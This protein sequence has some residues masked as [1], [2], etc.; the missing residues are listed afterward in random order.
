MR[1]LSH[2][3]VISDNLWEPLEIFKPPAQR[4]EKTEVC[5]ASKQAPGG[6]GQ[7]RVKCKFHAADPVLRSSSQ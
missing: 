5:E 6:L 7:N 3:C 2:R 1:S 4:D